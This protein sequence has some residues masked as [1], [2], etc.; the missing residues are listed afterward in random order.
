MNPE[1]SDRRAVAFGLGAVVLWSTVATAFNLS[2]D[3]VPPLTL[4]TLASIT[5]WL[6]LGGILLFSGDLGTL[7]QI[8][9]SEWLRLSAL[10]LINPTLYYFLLFGAY[11]RLPAQEAMAINYTWGLV[12]PL[13]AVPLLGQAL[14]RRDI[15][16]AAISYCGV[17]V[18]ATR[19]DVLSFELSD[20]TGVGLAMA[21]TVL[22]AL[23]WIGNTR[24]ST[25]PIQGL[26][27]G[28]TA[29]TVVLL[30]LA[31]LTG[32]LVNLPWQ[33]LAGGLYI[34]FFEMGLS[35]IL[36]LK[37]MKLT[38]NTARISTLIFLS[39]PL[40]LILIWAL[41]GEA[42]K[43]STLVGLAMI[44]TGLAMQ[45]WRRPHDPSV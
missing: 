24:I 13:L 37:A 1:P 25:P 45:H 15:G 12:L 17:F 38:Q 18:I 44:L 42:I 16:C 8:K 4:V 40:S 22:W 19:G 21:S 43:G 31:G 26:F 5:S 33:A 35:F 3:Y 27:V 32:S 34:G 30:T 14:K 7:N 9:I 41:L 39:P 29:A 20:P 2:L 6:F 28:F 10:G 23:Y 36:W 11:A